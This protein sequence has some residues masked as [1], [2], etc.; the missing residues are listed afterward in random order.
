MTASTFATT[1]GGILLTA[2][3]AAFAPLVFLVCEAIAAMAWTAGT[4]DY[5]HNFISDLGTTVCG[6]VYAGREM[7]SPLHGV[8]NFGFIAMGWG[9][10]AF[11]ALM[12]TRLLRVRRVVVTVL[13]LL[14]AFGMT[15]VAVIHGGIESVANGTGYLHMLGA[16]IAIVVG[17]ALAIVAGLS[18]PRLGLAR[19]Y[20]PASIACGVVGLIGLALLQ[21][22]VAFLD[23]AI[24]E[25][26]AVYAIFAW[27]LST[28]VAHLLAWRRTPR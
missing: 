6:S 23:P 27:H 7:C 1:R 19:W 4:Y 25:R 22:G 5:G 16:G 11:A 8:M 28:S 17:N 10:A 21:S 20:R 14:V 3:I 9:V 18:G 15:L 26:V 2:V 12:A 24:F 13:G